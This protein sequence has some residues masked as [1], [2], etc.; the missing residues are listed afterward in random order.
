MSGLKAPLHGRTHLP[1]GSDPITP[2]GSGIQFDTDPQSGDWLTWDTTSFDPITGNG[3]DITVGGGNDMVVHQTDTGGPA[4]RWECD[5]GTSEMLLRDY[6][7]QV[8]VSSGATIAVA[9]PL[10][11]GFGSL[12]LSLNVHHAINMGETTKNTTLNV[13]ADGVVL[14]RKPT[15]GLFSVSDNTG[16]GTV[17][18]LCGRFEVQSKFPHNTYFSVDDA[19]DTATT[20]Y[21]K[22][23]AGNL[24]FQID[25]DGDVHIKTGKTI[26]AD[27]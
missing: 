17:G 27:L 2:F 19:G 26:T 6:E 4:L 13:P 5:G 15:D 7:W 11:A 22:D 21:V 14:V 24:I 9:S 3:L 12:D 18:V 1:G 16:Q 10:G 25:D 20:V 23:N 8:Y